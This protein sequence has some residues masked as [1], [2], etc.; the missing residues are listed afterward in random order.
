MLSPLESKHT[1]RRRYGKPGRDL[2]ENGDTSFIMIS[3]WVSGPKSSDLGSMRYIQVHRPP[4]FFPQTAWRSTEL[5]LRS[6][7]LQC[8]RK[9]NSCILSS[10]EKLEAGRKTS[11]WFLFQ[12]LFT[13]IMKS[14]SSFFLLVLSQQPRVGLRLSHLV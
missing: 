10:K 2:T 5:K 8:H 4:K 14:G 13:E 11:V 1:E 12:E 3:S 9:D 6:P 7:A